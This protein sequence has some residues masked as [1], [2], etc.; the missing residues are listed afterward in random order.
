MYANVNK[1]SPKEDSISGSA[2]DGS[3]CKKGIGALESTFASSS[4][5]TSSSSHSNASD[6]SDHKSEN[7][8][9]EY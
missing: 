4:V 3:K 9:F 8:P 2:S 6:D 5:L 7:N 1:G